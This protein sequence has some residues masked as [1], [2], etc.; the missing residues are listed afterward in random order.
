VT[1]RIS[2]PEPGSVRDKQATAVVMLGRLL[3][4]DLPDLIWHVYPEDAPALEGQPFVVHDE[5]ASVDV[6]NAWAEFLDVAVRTEPYDS[7]ILVEVKAIR[8]GVSI[9]IYAHVNV[10]YDFVQV[11]KGVAQTGGAS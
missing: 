6:L 1:N 3:M 10:T 5:K 8:D 9:R 7:Y 2:K 4:N 11:A